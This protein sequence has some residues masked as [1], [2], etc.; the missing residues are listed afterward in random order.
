MPSMTMNIIKYVT[1][2]YACAVHVLYMC[3]ACA[4]HVVIPVIIE[5]SGLKLFYEE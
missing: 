5:S 3:C 4:L 1:I 2:Y